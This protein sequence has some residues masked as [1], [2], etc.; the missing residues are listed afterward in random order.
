MDNPIWAKVELKK[1]LSEDDILKALSKVPIFSDLIPKEIVEISKIV[2][3]RNYQ[4]NE[5][6]FKM[7]DPGLGM[8][9]ILEGVVDIVKEV[10]NKVHKL[11]SLDQGSFFGD[12]ALL[13]EAPR[14]AS[15]IAVERSI[16]IG[17]F[18]PDLLDLLRRKPKCGIKI[19]FNLTKVMSARL[20]NTNRQLVELENKYKDK[21]NG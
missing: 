19:L 6:I 3:K 5:P 17:F 2:Y 18:R 13:D 10:N 8:Y 12:L 11:A 21:Q 15:A 9:I 20:R 7:D 1:K 14:S 4:K 16:I